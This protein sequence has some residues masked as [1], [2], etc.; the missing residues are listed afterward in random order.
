[1]TQSPDN[2]GGFHTGCSPELL[3]ESEKGNTYGNKKYLFAVSQLHFVRSRKHKGDS[4]SFVCTV[5]FSLKP[6]ASINYMQ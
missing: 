5:S 3:S 1:M 2:E 6:L 4:L